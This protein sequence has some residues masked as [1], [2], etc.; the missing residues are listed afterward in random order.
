MDLEEAVAVF[1]EVRPRLFGIAYR[2]LGS[3]TEAED[4][5]Q[6][7]WLRWQ[8]YDRAGVGNPA[9]FLATTTTRLAIN[10]LQSARV[11][12]ETYIGPW[13]PEPVDTGADPYLGAERGEAL[14]FAVLVLLERLSP[15]ERAAYVLREAF[16][17][18][19]RQIADIVGLN[20]AAVR[21]LVSR[22]RKRVLVERRKPVAGAEQRRLLTAFVT[23]ARAGDLTALEE[24]FAADVTS[25]SDGGGA[26]R[27]S[28]IPVVGSTRVAKYVKAFAS[29]FWTGVDVAWATMNGQAAALL[30]RDGEVFTVLTVN[31]S[32][33]GIDEVLWLMNPAKLNGVSTPAT[34]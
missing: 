28:R 1:A 33:Q 2:M 31:A 9:A 7:V 26:V 5:L 4:L 23:A 12:R 13:L 27:A 34:S 30:S 11:R 25:Y 32:E 3:A 17:Y 22:A 21:Q 10:A 20:E 19:Y 24:L 16:D 18:P 8:A 14:E 29:H 6:E 15:T